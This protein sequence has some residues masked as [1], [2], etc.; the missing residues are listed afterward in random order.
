[1][2]TMQQQQRRTG[3]ARKKAKKNVS[4]AA[5][6]QE[7]AKK[8]RRWRPGTVVLREIKKYQA[9]DKPMIAKTKFQRLVREIDAE[10]G[11]KNFNSNEQQHRW[12]HA[13]LEAIQEATEAYIVTVLSDANMC[14][15]HAK[16]ETVMPR[17]LR[18]AQRLRG[19]R[20]N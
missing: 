15:L 16:R 7:Q 4:F 2:T 1:M 13:A 6:D 9:S 19:D 17:D 14:A 12:S 18:L 5:G 20:I 11:V 10:V 3:M 8:P